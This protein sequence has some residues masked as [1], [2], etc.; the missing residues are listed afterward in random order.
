AAEDLDDEVRSAVVQIQSGAERVGAVVRNLQIFARQQRSGM[1]AIQINSLIAQ[2]LALKQSE[3]ALDGIE[4]RKELADRLPATWGD[5][6]QI[7]QVLLNL[8]INAQHALRE[9]SAPGSI[10]IRTWVGHSDGLAAD[11]A[12]RIYISIADNGPGIPAELM[13]RIFEPFFTTKPVGQGTGLGLSV[14]YGIIAD[15]GGGVLGAAQ[16]GPSARFRIEVPRRE[17][18][19]AQSVLAIPHTGRPAAPPSDRRILLV[20]DDVS[21]VYLVR[22]ALEHGNSLV[23]AADGRQALGILEVE[24]FDLVLCDLRMP[25]MGGP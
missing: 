21:V 20:D 8:L 15:H 3:L 23:V 22:S 24:R 2:T 10:T 5:A 4:V 9:L 1:S 6:A 25:G 17:A 16:T 11:G 13:P 12:E 18:V 19:P 7:S 14:C